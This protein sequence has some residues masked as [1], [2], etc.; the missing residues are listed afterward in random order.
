MQ[1][2][3]HCPVPPK[4]GPPYV[5][6]IGGLDPSGGAGLARDLLTAMALG[7]QAVLVGTAWT[8]QD[9]RGARG[10]EPRHPNM[11]QAAIEHA[12]ESCDPERTAVKIGMTGNGTLIAAIVS[13]LNAWTGPVVFDPV[14]G[15]SSGGTTLFQ[16]APA[17]MLPLVHRATLVTPN[18][19]EASWLTGQPV[20]TREEAHRAA[21]TLSSWGKTSILVKGGHLDGPP[22]DVLASPEG[23]QLFEGVRLP[24]KSPR[25]TGC[26]L[27][28]AI[29][30]KLAA[31][32]PLAQA[33]HAAKGWLAARIA[34]ATEIDG[35]RF[36]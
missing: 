10:I 31:G 4:P 28:T 9:E 1:E 3:T 5:V 15:A 8:R 24:G 36:L 35:A 7:G 6:A 27:A 23:E 25:G 12:L 11:L 33:V 20:S 32:H 30:L 14:L 2:T 13:G 26:T 22:V 17:D 21:R 16:G 19:A 29:A 18:L 34:A